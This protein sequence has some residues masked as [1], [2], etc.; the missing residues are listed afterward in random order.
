MR[1][2][3]EAVQAGDQR[4]VRRQRL[5]ARS[6]AA[7]EGALTGYLDAIAEDAAALGAALAPPAW[8]D[9]DWPAKI[10]DLVA[11][12]VPIVS[13]TFGCPDPDVIA[14]LRAAG[15][16]VWVTVTDEDEAAIAVARRSGLPV[17]AGR[18]SGRA[19]RHV[20]E[21]GRRY[22]R[23][24]LELVAAVRPATDAAAGRGRR[25]HD[26]RGRRRGPGRG[27]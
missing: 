8:D 17:R 25:H 15:S 1:A 2:E 23:G 13:F 24:T 18:R 6:P 3:I 4:G 20:H 10:A 9:D 7:D 14:A 19:P 27:R 11:R 16:S 22:A 21:P 12:P 5:H 26:R